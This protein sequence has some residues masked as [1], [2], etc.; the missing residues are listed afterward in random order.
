MSNSSRI[1]QHFTGEL[2]FFQCTALDPSGDTHYILLSLNNG[3]SMTIPEYE[4]VAEAPD[5]PTVNLT[6][7]SK[8]YIQIEDVHNMISQV[9][10]GNL[11]REIQSR[12]DCPVD[13][14]NPSSI[15]REEFIGGRL[16]DIFVDEDNSYTDFDQISPAFGT[17]EEARK[18]LDDRGLCSQYSVIRRI[19]IL[20]DFD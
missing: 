11:L 9:P 17:Y 13:F 3:I 12:S 20:L 16:Q 7:Q 18:W 4:F 6:G 10:T 5:D 19:H 8:A 2:Y 15:F 14:L 1:F